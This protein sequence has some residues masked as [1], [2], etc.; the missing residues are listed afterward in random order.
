MP[1]PSFVTRL[2]VRALPFAALLALPLW[3]LS[4]CEQ[5]DDVVAS[6]AALPPMMPEPDAGAPSC[7]TSQLY[8]L[9]SSIV[10]NDCLVPSSTASRTVLGMYFL[11]NPPTGS[12]PGEAR[13]PATCDLIGIDPRINW[14]YRRE[15]GSDQ[16][17]V[18]PAHCELLKQYVADEDQRLLEC[19]GFGG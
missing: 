6:L 18:C 12:T 5:S 17:G 9:F 3:S 15:E 10:R 16:L 8:V 19:Q 13:P 4:G 1:R 2:L 7:E 11:R 14:V